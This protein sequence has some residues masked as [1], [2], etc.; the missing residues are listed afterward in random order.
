M[1]FDER[2]VDAVEGNDANDG[3][4]GNPKKTIFGASGAA[5]V[6]QA[7]QRWNVKASASY[8]YNQVGAVSWAKSGV[9]G[10]VD[11]PIV[12]RGYT[13]TPG[14][15]GRVT[16]VSTAPTLNWP[17]ISFATDP[18]VVLIEGFNI[19]GKT[20]GYG[21]LI[22]LNDAAPCFV[23]CAFVNDYTGSTLGS[24]NIFDDASIVRCYQCYFKISATNAASAIGVFSDYTSFIG[25][26]FVTPRNGIHIGGTAGGYIGNSIV[27]STSSGSISNSCYGISCKSDVASRKV[28]MH[29]YVKGFHK[30]LYYVGNDSPVIMNNIFDNNTYSIYFQSAFDLIIPAILNNGLV[31]T[32]NLTNNIPALQATVIIPT[33]AITGTPT[34][35]IPGGDYR[36][37]LTAAETFQAGYPP[38][39]GASY[40]TVDSRASLLSMGPYAPHDWPIASDVRDGVSCAHGTV[41]GTLELPVVDLPAVEDVRDGVLFDNGDKEGTLDLPSEYSV[42]YGVLFDGESKEGTLVLPAVE[43][44]RDGVL[45]D[46]FGDGEQIGTLDLP[47]ESTVQYGVK[48]DNETKTGTYLPGTGTVP[49]DITFEDNSDVVS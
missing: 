24:G 18:G 28:V 21:A 36:I 45:F 22:T 4:A 11:A 19:V 8:T 42:R 39:I 38:V 12:W 30:G 44:V 41:T 26:V 49:R 15:G 37:A 46:S 10:T 23:K 27:Y 20:G 7:G 3:T 1:A 33:I 5:S 35:D 40:T 6:Q 13:T 17:G 29:N 31:G 43:D 2:Y 9:I 34:V 25:C 32:G 16:L 48:Y 47:L 14:D